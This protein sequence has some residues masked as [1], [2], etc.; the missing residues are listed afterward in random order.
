MARKIDKLEKRWCDQ[1]YRLIDN[2]PETLEI[3]IDNPTGS[4]LIKDASSG[5]IFFHISHNWESVPSVSVPQNQDV[6]NT[7]GL[8]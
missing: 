3:L 2:Q 1:L 5:H 6:K 7:Y 4:F 8:F